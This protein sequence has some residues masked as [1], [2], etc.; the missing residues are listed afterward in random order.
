M[1]RDHRAA[2]GVPDRKL[3]GENRGVYQRRS[4]HEHRKNLIAIFLENLFFDRNK[5]RQRRAG[6]GRITHRQLLQ[7][8]LAGTC[9]RTAERENHSDQRETDPGSR[10]NASCVYMLFNLP[11]GNS[12]QA[13][14]HCARLVS[15]TALKRQPELDTSVGAEGFTITVEM[16]FVRCCGRTRIQGAMTRTTYDVGLSYA[17]TA[18]GSVKV[19]FEPLPALL[20]TQILPP[21]SSTNFFAKV[22]PSPVPSALCA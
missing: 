10:H 1:A 7:F 21:C 9:R 14:S 3:T 22:K 20:V 16:L 15:I 5:Q 19:N 13:L 11:G 8:F 6:N 17:A 12:S 2:A 18:S 4:A